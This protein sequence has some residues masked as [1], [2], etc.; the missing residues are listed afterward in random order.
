V[1]DDEFLAKLSAEDR[2]QLALATQEFPEEA[3]K[4]AA[5]TRAA[6]A[7]RDA[8]KQQRRSGPRGRS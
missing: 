4:L 7:S 2:Q 5:I 8:A 3:A 1:F 6:R